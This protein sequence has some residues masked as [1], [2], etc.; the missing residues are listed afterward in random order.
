MFSL[1]RPAFSSRRRPTRPDNFPTRMSAP[2][3]ARGSPSAAPSSRPV[4][5]SSTVTSLTKPYN[6]PLWCR[7]IHRRRPAH[8]R[9]V[10]LTNGAAGRWPWGM[11]YMYI[12]SFMSA[13]WSSVV[14][15]PIAETITT[16]SLSSPGCSTSTTVLQ[17]MELWRSGSPCSAFWPLSRCDAR[18][19][20]GRQCGRMGVVQTI[21]WLAAASW[22]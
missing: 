17:L 11:W 13:L 20:R 14:S 9:L 6:H 19:P 18:G 16:N 8:Q 22:I 4:Q 2:F 5:P 21:A 10:R 7:R 1:A 15:S 3:S 12:V